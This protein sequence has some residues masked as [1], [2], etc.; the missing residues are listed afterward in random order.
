MQRNLLK[1]IIPCAIKC[2][3]GSISTSLA[4]NQGIV[5]VSYVHEAIKKI[6]SC[7]IQYLHALYGAS[8]KRAFQHQYQKFIIEKMLF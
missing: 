3:V 4:T 6:L 5:M 2:K 1:R 8:L 7:A